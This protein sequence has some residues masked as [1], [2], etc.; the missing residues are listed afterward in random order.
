MVNVGAKCSSAL[1]VVLAKRMT[2]TVGTGE[3]QMNRGFRA[4]L[5]LV[6]SER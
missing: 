1:T 2:V 6:G 3:V 4:A 5:V